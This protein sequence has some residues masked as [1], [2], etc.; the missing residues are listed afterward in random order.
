MGNFLSHHKGI[1]RDKINAMNAYINSRS[2][3]V[4]DVSFYV[5]DKNRKYRQH[6]ETLTSRA[7]MDRLVRETAKKRVAR[8]EYEE[9]MFAGPSAWHFEDENRGGRRT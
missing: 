6:F 2:D 3:A 7:E 4:I 9:K 8:F 5:R 1:P